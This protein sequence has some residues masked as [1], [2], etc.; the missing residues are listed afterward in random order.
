MVDDVG[1]KRGEGTVLF[2][3]GLDAD[4]EQLARA[5]GSHAGDE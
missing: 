4:D 5:I 2:G 1:L 3:N